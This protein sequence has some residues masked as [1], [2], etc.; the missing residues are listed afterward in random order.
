MKWIKCI[1]QLPGKYKKILISNGKDVCV[2]T[3][4]S[5]FDSLIY[6]S[7]YCDDCPAGG[8]ED[9]GVTHWMPLPDAPKE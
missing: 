4:Q 2:G 5:A 3:Q 7:R 1:D 8:N 9:Y 6:C